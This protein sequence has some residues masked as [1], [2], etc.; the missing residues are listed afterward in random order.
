MIRGLCPTASTGLGECHTANHWS[1]GRAP[2]FQESSPYSEFTLNPCFA[3]KIQ[4]LALFKTHFLYL[5]AEVKS[6]QRSAHNAVSNTTVCL[7][8]PHGTGLEQISSYLG[9][10]DFKLQHYVRSKEFH[11]LGGFTAFLSALVLLHLNFL[12]FPHECQS[13]LF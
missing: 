12:K 1:I 13:C 6:L 9:G 8:S 11:P 5:L 7:L 10:R 4:I 3:Y 2:S